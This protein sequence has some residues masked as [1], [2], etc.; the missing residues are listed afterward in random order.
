LY[1]KEAGNV[2]YPASLQNI[3]AFSLSDKT[4]CARDTYRSV[5]RRDVPGEACGSLGMP[6]AGAGS[7]DGARAARP[8]ERVKRAA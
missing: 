5:G 8:A 4:P 3:T 6:P 2:W 1:K 7:D